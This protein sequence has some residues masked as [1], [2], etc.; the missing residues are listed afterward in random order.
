ML[1]PACYGK[2]FVGG[3]PCP[4]CGGLGV[5]YCCEGEAEQP[6]PPPRPDD[7]GRTRGSGEE[8]APTGRADGALPGEDI[9]PGRAARDG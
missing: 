8:E 4:A 2:C 7:A 9:P 5:D 6:P 1:C 3:R